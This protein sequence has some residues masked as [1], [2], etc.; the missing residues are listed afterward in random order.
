MITTAKTELTVDDVLKIFSNYLKSDSYRYIQM[1]ESYYNSANPE[2]VKRF[3]RKQ[4]QRKEPNTLIPTAYYPTLVDNLSG[5]LF[6]NV[7]YV[8]E[9]HNVD[10]EGDDIDNS[11]NTQNELSEIL[12]KTF[13]DINVDVVDIQT[14]TKAIAYNKGVELVYTKGDGINP[15]EIRVVS[16]DPKSVITIYSDDIEPVL[17]YAILFNKVD[18]K[19]GSVK[20]TY[21]LTVIDKSGIVYYQITDKNE[22]QVNADKEPVITVWSECPVVEYKTEVLNENSCFHQILPYIDALD[23]L[24]SGNSDEVSRLADAILKLSSKL[25]EE[26]KKNLNELRVIEGIGKDEIAE[27]ITRNTDSSFREYVSKL[28][29]QE[30][31]RHSHMVDMYTSDSAAG[32]ASGKALKVRLTD[33]NT[34]CDRIEKSVKLGWQKRIRLFKDFFLKDKRISE[35]AAQTNI[36]TVFNRTKIIG[37][38][39]I[40]SQLTQPTFISDETKQELCG[41]DPEQ[42]GKRLDKQKENSG[43]DISDLLPK[44]ITPESN[45]DTSK[46]EPVAEDKNALG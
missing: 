7:K 45:A 15:A 13:S 3:N 24:I 35:D 1:L 8:A 21:D 2:I 14:G 42:E 38:E 36:K 34:F 39:D 23:I 33:Q 26:Q 27:F 10:V 46:E 18:Y 19:A 11:D 41:L 37:V 5:Y 29:I 6:G 25:S 28:L 22:I 16:L 9:T 31:Y 32:D 17:T 43:F 44:D 12:N 30:I 40:A 4:W 20:I